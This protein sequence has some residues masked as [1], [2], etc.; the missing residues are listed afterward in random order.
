ME[1]RIRFLIIERMRY[2]NR[3]LKR[4]KKVKVGPRQ[5][6]L[7]WRRGCSCLWQLRIRLGGAV[8]ALQAYVPLSCWLELFYCSVYSMLLEELHGPLGLCMCEGVCTWGAKT[9]TCWVSSVSQCFQARGAGTARRD[10][11]VCLAFLFFTPPSFALSNLRV[12]TQTCLCVHIFMPSC[13]RVF[14]LRCL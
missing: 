3:L 10:Q 11:K 4:E 1:F 12:S 13:G 7:S 6:L 14:D 5:N 8:I 9:E 2:W